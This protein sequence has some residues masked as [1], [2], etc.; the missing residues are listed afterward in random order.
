MASSSASRF[1]RQASARSRS[2]DCR[3]FPAPLTRLSSCTFHFG[4]I[5]T[6][7]PFCSIFYLQK[8]IV[9]AIFTIAITILRRCAS[10]PEPAPSPRH[11]LCRYRRDAAGLAVR[12][13]SGQ[14]LAQPPTLGLGSVEPGAEI[15][16]RFFLLRN[17]V[18]LRCDDSLAV[19]LLLCIRCAL[20]A[21]IAPFNPSPG[22]SP[23]HAVKLR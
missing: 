3:A 19:A 22:W 1:F 16:N 18:A 7:L 14:P 8:C 20:A 15:A 12:Q 4:P 9:T 21:G 2:S 13:Q 10:S 11:P 17:R 5:A 23:K 6:P